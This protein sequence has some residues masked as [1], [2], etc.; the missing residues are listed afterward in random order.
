MM[1]DFYSLSLRF[2]ISFLDLIVK[3][4]EIKRLNQLMDKEVKRYV[5]GTLIAIDGKHHLIVGV[6]TE[7]KEASD[8]ISNERIGIITVQYVKDNKIAKFSNVV[9]S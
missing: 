8:I 4:S 3:R 6:S 2:M 9:K 1:R 7:T 5:P